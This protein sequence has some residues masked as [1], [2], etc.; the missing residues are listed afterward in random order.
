MTLGIPRKPH[1]SRAYRIPR[2]DKH[3]SAGSIAGPGVRIY[4]S[5]RLPGRLATHRPTVAAAHVYL[6]ES[7]PGLKSLCAVAGT[8]TPPGS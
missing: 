3:C 1:P 4:T 5:W 2:L 6:A 8:R 7:T